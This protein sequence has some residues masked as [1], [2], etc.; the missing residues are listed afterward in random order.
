[1]PNIKQ[2]NAV[3]PSVDVGAYSMIWHF[4]T[5]LYGTKIG[6]YVCIGS[7]CW[8]GKGVTIGDETRIQ[9][10]VFIPNDTI[11]GERVFIGPHVCMTDD[12]YPKVR[13]DYHAEPPI[14]EDDVSI[15][16]NAT[17]LPGV[18]LGKGS[19]VG[20]GAVVTHD[21]PEGATVVG[22]PAQIIQPKAEA[23]GN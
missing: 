4:T 5:I 13:G 9:T 10:G 16:A 15:G 14:I 1:M 3:D 11:I 7:H 21:V 18:R 2:P 23:Y 8:I 17:I 19:M 6:E 12:R 22:C 20:A